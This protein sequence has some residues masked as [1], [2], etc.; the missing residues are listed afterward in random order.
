MKKFINIFNWGTAIILSFIYSII[1]VICISFIS[2]IKDSLGKFTLKIEWLPFG[3]L[4]LFFLGLWI[5]FNLLL[6]KLKFDKNNF[7]RS[8]LIILLI[9]PLFFLAYDI[10]P[11]ENDYTWEDVIT[12]KKE[13]EKSYNTFNK[14]AKIDIDY[15]FTNISSAIINTNI[16]AYSDIIQKS[17]ENNIEARKL[18]KEL[19]S[20]SEIADLTTKLDDNYINTIKSFGQIMRLY[21]IYIKLK[22]EENDLAL[23]TDLLLTINSIFQKS[24]PYS[25]TFLQRL[26]W[27]SVDNNINARVNSIIT[28]ENCS[29]AIIQKFKNSIINTDLNFE[30]CLI[31]EYLLF[32]NLLENNFVSVINKPNFLKTTLTKVGTKFLVNKNRTL[33]DEKKSMDIFISCL[34]NQPTN[35]T[36][37]KKHIKFYKSNPQFRNP[38][39]WL[40]NNIGTSWL[41]IYENSQKIHNRRK[42]LVEKSQKL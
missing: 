5:L 36:A 10:P 4:F 19:N 22:I 42:E 11:V 31:S 23:A 25:K 6:N 7:F 18:I 3:V 26:I 41:T 17:W 21:V 16:L 38:I 30:S 32:K 15:S 37:Y 1:F 40:L 8:L 2:S 34:T 12:P 20:F 14:F 24:Y 35:F 39:G 29:V 9:F 13:A 33:R 28:N 27:E